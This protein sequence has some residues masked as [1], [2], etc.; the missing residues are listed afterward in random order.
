MKLSSDLS[1]TACRISGS[2]VDAVAAAYFT[3]AGVTDATAKTRI[4]DFVVGLKAASLFSLL[5]ACWIGRSAYNAGSGSTVY[6]LS[7]DLLNGTFVNSP[8]W[9]A[10]GLSFSA[11]TQA[12]TTGR[13]QTM[14]GNWSA[15]A[16]AS[17]GVGDTGSSRRVFGSPGAGPA[18]LLFLTDTDKTT[19]RIGAYDLVVFPSTGNIDITTLRMIGT[20]SSAGAQS[21][22]S[23]ATA[24]GT[25][26]ASFAAASHT[27]Q[28]NNDS[29]DG[30][31]AGLLSVALVFG[32]TKL[33]GTQVSSL[34]TLLKTTI[35]SD[36]GLP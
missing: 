21:F 3:R 4:N 29:G 25:A 2:G 14:D 27:V 7:S 9:S 23:G 10:S 19:T 33:N 6:E 20:A 1:L 30:M 8:S 12:V 28:L 31:S 22:Y 24:V 35:C 26:A 32:S 13:T 18:S 11:G 5:S 16:V 34:Y 15:F 17:D 36:Q